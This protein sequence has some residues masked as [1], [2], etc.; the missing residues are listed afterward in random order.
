MKRKIVNERCE[1]ALK[2]YS[3]QEGVLLKIMC[4]RGGVT[5]IVEREILILW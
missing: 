5:D 4:V 1:S 3:F 2:G